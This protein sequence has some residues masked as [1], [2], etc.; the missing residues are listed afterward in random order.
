[1]LFWIAILVGIVVGTLA[2]RIGFYETLI[3]SFNLAVSVYLAVFLTPYVVTHVP[4]ATEIDAGLPLTLVGLAVGSF[5]LLHGI[6]YLLFTGQFT[7]AFPKV[8][9]LPFSALIGFGAGVLIVSLVALILSIT[10]SP[11]GETILGQ[12]TLENHTAALRSS[13]NRIHRFVKVGES[14]VD[15]GQILAW[16]ADSKKAGEERPPVE[17]RDVN[18]A[19]GAPPDDAATHSI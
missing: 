18:E 13:C 16:L 2:T 10:P 5:I 19:A 7:I 12:G 15:T 14:A 6:S 4:A 17:S 9:D 1:M 11:W 8:I 3:Y